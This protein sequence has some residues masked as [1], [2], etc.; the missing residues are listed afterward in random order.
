MS[1]VEVLAPLRI[2]TRFYSPEGERAAW[3]LRIRVYPDEFSMERSPP[4]ASP[5]ELDL[6]DDILCNYPGDGATQMHLLASRL[7][8][9]RAIWLRRT[10]SIEIVDGVP[11]TTRSS[12]QARDPKRYPSIHKPY[13]LPPAINVWLLKRGDTAPTLAGTM[14]PDRVRIAAELDLEGFV[15]STDIADGKL[16]PTWWTSFDIAR[17]AGLAI[18][19][20][21]PSDEPLPEF[22]AIVVCGLGDMAPGPLV[23]THAAT[24]RLAVLKPG[25]PTN[26]VNG[27]PTVEMASA[28]PGWQSVDNEP[29]DIQSA[30]RVVMNMLSGFGAPPIRLQGGDIP[31]AGHGP[32]L[33]KALWPVLWG[34]ALRDMIGIGAAEADLAEWAIAHLAPEGPYP[35]IRVGPQP[36]GLLP[37]SL[38]TEWMD[39]N[40]TEKHIREW[41]IGWRDAAAADAIATPGSVV[42][43]AA[44]QAVAF[45]GMDAPTSHWGIRPVSSLPVVNAM[46]VLHGQTVSTPTRWEQ[47]TAASLAGV[48][49]PLAPLAPFDRV[50]SL[51]SSTPEGSGDDP[52]TLRALINSDSEAFP[53]RW[54]RKLGLLGHLIF[55]T[56]CLL[57]ASVGQARMAAAAGMQVDP[58]QPLP[59]QAGTGELIALVQKGIAGPA[60]NPQVNDLLAGDVGARKIAERYIGAMKALVGLVDAYGKDAD[61]VF[62]CLL[63]ALDTASHRVDPWITGIADVRLRQMGQQR[64]PFFL[65]AYGWVDRPAP[66]DETSHGSGLPPGP[67]AAG[68][69]HAPSQTQAMTAALLRD[70]A[71]RYPGD[72]RWDIAIDSAKVRAAMRLAERVRL[73]V[74][75]Y[76]ALGLEVER[77]V[78]DWDVVRELRQQY[79]LRD[80]HQGRRCCDGAR[81][82]RLLFRRQPGDPPAPVLPANVRKQLQDYEAALD[83]YADLLIADGIHALVSGQGGVGNAAMEAA[84]G[85]GAPPDLRSIR[86][87]RKAVVV[88][89]SVWAL[90]PP[91]D[92]SALSPA[93]YADPAFAQ[94]LDAELG[95]PDSWT[96]SVGT[97]TVSLA[98]SNLHGAET[99]VLNDEALTR[100]LRGGLDPALLL[101]SSG[102]AEKRARANRLAELLGGGDS[103][104]PIPDPDSGRDD[105]R[106]SA[107]PLRTAM[108]ADLT[109]RFDTL[110]TRL[111]TL[112]AAFD[113]AD[114]NDPAVTAWFLSRFQLW[115]AVESADQDPLAQARAR[116]Q[117]RLSDAAPMPGVNALRHGIRTLVGNARLPVLPVVA[118]HLVGSMRTST[119]DADGR[120]ETDRSWLEIVAAVRPRL[121]LLEALQL[122]PDRTPWGAAIGTTDSSGDP[123]TVNGPV[124][125]A[126][127]PNPGVLPGR[128]AIAGLDAWQDA[129]PSNQHVTSAAFGFNGPKS[130]PP[131]AVLLA[132]PPDPNQRLTESQ[133][134]AVVLDTRQL[135]R[136]RACRPRTGSRIATPGALLSFPAQ[137]L[138]QWL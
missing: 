11:R 120:P 27:E 102:G 60:T 55:D 63:A 115:Q 131:Q 133:L 41:A 127:G 103:D 49:A 101:H 54:E 72:K 56:I 88:R 58:S 84:A 83:T 116:L 79:P 99:L 114:L 93:L 113:G 94:L 68:L 69:L 28:P 126:Y 90:L 135:A 76:E 81:V 92:A 67:T 26:T 3:L 57:R 32:L 45:L 66:Y 35:A 48:G 82:L 61:G 7:G 80:S 1:C 20:S 19:I 5:Q 52:D 75:P 6:F 47:N 38:L 8:A 78:G 134:A 22:E 30:S 108:L 98:D 62:N 118:S 121:A 31:A 104:P 25:T 137:F 43:A 132:V 77:V 109:E 119:I 122:D 37:T 111:Q 15:A 125:V 107:S 71:I 91:G 9:E 50:F 29:P 21:F 23:T 89:V 110:K 16:P 117:R 34:H 128:V 124:T 18:E 53:F 14:F 100:T 40:R 10:V 12:A 59:L 2:E 123:W 86:T 87:P 85:L 51:P 105:E 39:E 138:D 4:P 129:I 112:L 65:G 106:A 74:H 97:Q 95:P 64:A 130:R 46:Q 42:E 44:E 70:A 136:A 17:D 96:W 24:G 13:G 36:Y 73:G 33:V